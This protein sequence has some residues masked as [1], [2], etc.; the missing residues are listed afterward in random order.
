MTETDSINFILILCIADSLLMILFQYCTWNWNIWRA[1]EPSHG[2]R[3]F[4]THLEGYW[5]GIYCFAGLQGTRCV[6]K[7]IILISYTNVKI[8]E[9]F[10]AVGLYMDVFMTIGTQVI[11]FFRCLKLSQS[12]TLCTAITKNLMFKA[13]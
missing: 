9:P 13:L 1:V 2:R 10:A 12:E 8:C 6:I 7:L 5:K 4:N 3:L 11:V